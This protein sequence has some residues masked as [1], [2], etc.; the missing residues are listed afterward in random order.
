LDQAVSISG[1]SNKTAVVFIEDLHQLPEQYAGSP[2]ILLNGTDL[3][4]D[5]AQHSDGIQDSDCRRFN[6]NGKE[7]EVPDVRSISERILKMLPSED[8]ETEQIR[9]GDLLIVKPGEKVPVDGR[10]ISGQTEI[11]ESM[12]TGE[13]LP[14]LKKQDDQVIAGTLNINKPFIMVAEKVGSETVLSQIVSMVREAQLTRPPIQKLADKLV[15][16]FI[17]IVLSVAIITFI[18]WYFIIG[19][20]FLFSLTTFIS[21]LVIACPC[22]LGLA[23]PT[24]LTVGLGKAAELGIL[25]KNAEV[26]EL[27]NKIDTIVLDKT[28]TI[29]EGKPEVIS[30][31][32]YEES[33][34][35]KG[36][37]KALENNSNHP[38]AGA[39]IEYLEKESVEQTIPVENAEE[40]AGQGITGEVSGIRYG[41]GNQKLLETLG[42]QV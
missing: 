19:K 30:A 9:K 8:I 31:I 26:L 16:Y 5:N 27:A 17:P 29:T 41:V 6:I 1:L 20:S 12:I 38:L 24:A 18:F 33:D 22:A 7:M 28:G 2:T 4:G 15:T 11:N 37:L 42:V 39:V 13:P 34:Y 25:I 23:T 35:L 40:I 14:V 21:I 32:W 3:F 10:I 36:I